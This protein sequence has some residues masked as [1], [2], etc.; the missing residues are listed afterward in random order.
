MI[1][2]EQALSYALSGD[3]IFIIGSGFS[4]QAINSLGM[5]LKS[6]KQLAEDLADKVNLD[7]DTPLEIASQEYIDAI[8]ERSLCHYLRELYEVVEYEDFY[9]AFTRIKELKVYTTNYDNLIE[10]IYQS[11]NKKINSY[12]LSKKLNKCNK[13]NMVMHLNGN[14][15]DLENELPSTFNLTHLSYNHSPLYETSWYPY[16]KDQIRGS[17]AVFIIGLSFKSDL[18]LRRLINSEPEITEKCFIV[19]SPDLSD[20]DQNYLSKYGHVLLNGIEQFCKDL[21]TS[22]PF[23]QEESLSTY[24]FKSFVEYKK[25]RAYNEATDKEMFDM[26]FLGQIGKNMFYQGK[27]ENFNCLVNRTKVDEALDHLKEGRSIIIHSDLGNGKSVFL[28]ELLYKLQ[29]YK[30]FFILSNQNEKINK[31]IELLCETNKK[32][33]IVINPYNLFLHDFEK[34][35][36]YDLK[37]IQFI[38]L[39]R[40]AMHENCC[41]IL[42]DIIEQMQGVNFSANPINL[43]TM[44]S[45]ELSEFSSIISRFG[46]WGENT[47]LSDS[48]K[49]QLLS[50][51]LQGKFQNILLYLFDECKIKEKFENIIRNIESDKLLMQ[52]LVLSFVNEVLELNFDIDDFNIIFIRDNIDKILRKKRDCIGELI[53]Y[54]SSKLRIKSSI[55]SKSLIGSSVVSKALVLDTLLMVFHRLDL[56][57]DGNKKYNDA[58]KTLSSASYLS[59]I[60]DYTLDSK[61]LV[62][63]YEKI[64]ENRFNKNNLFFWQQYAITCVNIKDFSRA[65]CYF[66]TSYSL[67]R[68]K[69][70]HFSTFQIDNHY[71]RYLLESQIF[72][73]NYS[74]AF[75]TFVNAHKLL[76]KRYVQ[77]DNI[78]D[79]FYQFRVAIIYK[80][81]YDIFF[82]SFN[83][84]EKEGFILRCQEMYDRLKTYMK[85]SSHQDFRK[86]INECQRNLEYI[87]NSYQNS[88]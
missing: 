24:K 72:S 56:L 9:N 34:F 45:T 14:V 2:Y 8:G 49:L 57:Y 78:N 28:N 29:N 32:I 3:A 10:F 58:L 47:N 70:G 41:G 73:R 38:L 36:N 31:E 54:N 66:E 6:G 7:K 25:Q 51:K 20:K 53:D 4:T 87:I 63:Y 74:E 65:K 35:K 27:E 17:K 40:S 61:I 46:F 26:F 22:L 77:D 67:A 5:K 48:D 1:T 60:F 11:N 85:G 18:D 21:N 71:A 43:N 64:K 30:V 59:F 16:I 19:E 83:E 62:E 33:L 68:K 79:R 44:N 39:S 50:N 37:N 86:Y 84:T 69:P 75:S 80:E 12:N 82:S 55:I 81:Y 23:E 88:L 42:Y 76:I 13:K 15:D 52:I